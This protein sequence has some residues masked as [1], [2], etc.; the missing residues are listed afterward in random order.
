MFAVLA[1][2]AALGLVASDGRNLPLLFIYSAAAAALLAAKPQNVSLLVVLAPLGAFLARGRGS[3]VTQRWL[4]AGMVG[5]LV[6]VGAGT[7]LLTPHANQEYYEYNAVFLEMLPNSPDPQADLRALGL[8]P[9][10]ARLSGTN[11]FQPDTPAREPG[12]KPEF[13]DRVSSTKILRFYLARPARLT[14]LLGRGAGD[15]LDFR[16]PEVG[17]FTR[18]EGRSPGA[19]TQSFAIWS[20][21]HAWV[22]NIAVILVVMTLCLAGLLR[23]R[24]QPACRPALVRAGGLFLALALAAVLQYALV[25]V[26]E[27]RNGLAKKMVLGNLLIDLSLIGG[28]A[29]LVSTWRTHRPDQPT[30]GLDGHP[31]DRLVGPPASS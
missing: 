12:F 27:G 2:G 14:A 22:G 8:D 15:A 7:Y 29:T 10:L 9:G 11:A 17:N 6:V 20:R 5:L 21:V 26:G 31:G 18:E 23:A 25:M 16:P 19:H 13:F 30:V 4:A 28:A 1:V 3:S 24:R